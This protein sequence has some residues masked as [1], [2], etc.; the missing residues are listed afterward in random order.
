MNEIANVCELVGADVD[1][2]RQAIGS[3]RRIGTSFL[4]PGVGYGGSCFPKDVK[5]LVKSAAR[6]GLR[7][8]DPAR[9]SRRSTTRQKSR[10]VVQDA[11][12]L[13]RA[14]GPDDRALGPGVQAAHRR[15]ARGAGDRD[16]R[17]AARARCA[18][19]APTIRRP[20]TRRAACSAIGSR[21]ARRATTRWTAPTRWPSS[22]SGT[23]SASR[24]SSGCE[25]LLKTPVV[26][27]GRNIYSPEQM[28]ALGFTYFSI[29][30]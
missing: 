19:C 6:Q 11:G 10:L 18:T 22:P 26:F 7:V 3:D 29:G 25:Q 16:H 8:P 5:A 13:R 20:P 14:Q 23:S 15:H 24:I 4:F 28:R 1:Q 30:R 12:A 2:V 17:A 27:D 21:S 9:R